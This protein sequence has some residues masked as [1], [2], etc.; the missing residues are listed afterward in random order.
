MNRAPGDP[1]DLPPEPVPPAAEG[2]PRPGRRRPLPGWVGW[3][4]PAAIL[5]GVVAFLVW[6]ADQPADP[7][8]VDA[9]PTSAPGPAGTDG[10]GPSPS[11]RT[12]P[13]PGLAET[14]AVVTTAAGESVELCLLVAETREER[15]QG[16]MGVTD[17]GGYDGM[18]FTFPTDTTAGFW[19]RQT[20]MPLTVAYFDADG[21][22]V[23]SADMTP[24]PEEECPTYPPE[25]PYRNAV[26][27]P[28]ERANEVGLA[29]G[30][31]LATGLAC[32]PPR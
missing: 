15:A 11:G 7:Y 26:E 22:L 19:M 31:E 24:C 30:A 29:P 16:L 18:L 6:A 9:A 32:P 28:V 1:T 10:P 20:P 27:V 23:S 4:V 14:G 2:P 13:V 8:L 12:S 3:A 17:L 5:A 25:G 21:E